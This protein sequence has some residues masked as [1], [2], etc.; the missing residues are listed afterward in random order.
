MNDQ[1]NKNYEEFKGAAENFKKEASE[2]FEQLGNNA[3]NQGGP[4]LSKLLSFDNM[5]AGKIIKVLYFLMLIGVIITGIGMIFTRDM[6][7]NRQI[8]SG[9]LVIL[10]GPFVVR[11][12]AE[13]AIIL[14]NIN[15]NLAEIKNML[16]YRK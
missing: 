6:W 14:F 5:I 10:I 3:R 9:I 16:K 2:R 4:F 7:G 1:N 13:L 12:W 11:I 8:L 15:D